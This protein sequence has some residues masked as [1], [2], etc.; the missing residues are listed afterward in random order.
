MPQ[1]AKHSDDLNLQRILRAPTWRARFFEAAANAAASVVK[2][3]IDR[4][5]TMGAARW[6]DRQRFFRE[7]AILSSETSAMDSV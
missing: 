1:P 5:D 7:K 4:Q 6:M 2:Y 3:S